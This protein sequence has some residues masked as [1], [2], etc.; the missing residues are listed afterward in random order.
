MSLSRLPQVALR[1]L[2][3]AISAV[4]KSL[5]D[6]Q[7]KKILDPQQQTTAAILAKSSLKSE[8]TAMSTTQGILSA[9]SKPTA[10]SSTLGRL[11][12]NLSGAQGVLSTQD[13]ALLKASTVPFYNTGNEVSLLTTPEPG[14]PG[15]E[16]LLTIDSEP[17]IGALDS[18][19]V[20]ALV[21]ALRG[22]AAISTSSPSTEFAAEYDTVPVTS[23]SPSRLPSAAVVASKRDSIS[24]AALEE[25]NQIASSMVVEDEDVYFDQSDDDL[26]PISNDL[27]AA[28]RRKEQ[29]RRAQK[30]FRQK[31][32][33]RQKEIKWRASQYEDLVES[34]KRFKR[35]ID[36]ISQ[37]RDMYRRILEQN[38]ITLGDVKPVVSEAGSSR[39]A[40]PTPSSS[41][42]AALNPVARSPSIAESTA[43]AS[44]AL[45]SSNSLGMDQIAQDTYGT[46]GM[47]QTSTVSMNDL[48]SSF[49]FGAVKSDPMFGST[50]GLFGPGGAAHR[51]LAT[52]PSLTATVSPSTSYAQS[53]SSL[54]GS[55]SPAA[56]EPLYTESPGMID[57]HVVDAPYV[58]ESQ[59]VDPMAFIDELLASSS[60]S[61]GFSPMPESPSFSPSVMHSSGSMSRKRSFDNAMF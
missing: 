31:D 59:L 10:S 35:D 15:P 16:H 1:R 48:F 54:L 50:V 61:P 38:G 24:T 5:D 60:S 44:P 56:S 34:N 17:A 39:I 3:P 22:T 8:L 57:H 52:L 27:S 23:T 33:V 19:S 14:S 12:M 55:M 46:V 13:L 7:L 29:N 18:A 36:S 53:M 26:A 30:K 40:R 47:P 41:T 20:D 58:A 11:L 51:S 21:S 6:D 42:L 25:H 4:P 45:M 32:K 2:M 37:E 49:M 9:L 43:T 28:E